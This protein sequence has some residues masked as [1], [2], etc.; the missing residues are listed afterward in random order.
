[1]Q[2]Y[3]KKTRTAASTNDQIIFAGRCVLYGVYPDVVT[4][5]T[6]TI[7]DDATATGTN[8]TVMAIGLLTAGK[9]YGPKG[10]LMEKGIT[11]KLSV[12]T[13]LSL[14]VWAPR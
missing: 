2:D 1:M 3:A 12:N 8:I 9:T 6:I 4:T 7:A 10:I 14:I 13:D 5:G 11:L